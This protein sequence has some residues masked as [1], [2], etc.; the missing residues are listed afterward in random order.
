M[1]WRKSCEREEKDGVFFVF[2]YK[3]QVVKAS[4]NEWSSLVG[5]YTKNAC[6]RKGAEE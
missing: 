6:E 5:V 4:M 2:L 1:N 3:K